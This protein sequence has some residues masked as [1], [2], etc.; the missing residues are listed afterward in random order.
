MSIFSVRAGRFS[1]IRF[2]Q[3]SMMSLLG[4]RIRALKSSFCFENS[5]KSSSIIFDFPEAVGITTKNVQIP[6]FRDF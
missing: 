1:D 2:F 6:F 3:S 5:F 4:A